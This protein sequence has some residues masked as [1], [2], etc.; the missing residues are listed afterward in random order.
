MARDWYVYIL[1]NNAHTLYVGATNGLPQRI[2][3]HKDRTYETSFTARYTFDRC[4][5][6]ERVGTQ[7][8]A[9]ARERQIKK[10]PRRRKVV[11][12]QT[13]NPN[14]IDLSGRWSLDR[15]LS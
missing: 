9:I 1:S 6:F 4:V 12:I 3:Q 8:A 14:W 7:K 11:L 10:W 15:V 13:T 2:R 5:Y